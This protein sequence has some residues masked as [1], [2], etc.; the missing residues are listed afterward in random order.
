MNVIKPGVDPKGK[1]YRGE[2]LHCKC[3]VEFLRS[4]AEYVSSCRNEE[5]LRVTCPT[6]KQDI[7]VDV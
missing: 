1:K 7:W 3:E 2:C 4:E 5:M 6:C